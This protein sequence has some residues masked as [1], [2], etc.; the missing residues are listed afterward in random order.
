MSAIWLLA[1]A[2][3]CLSGKWAQHCGH[4]IC[5]NILELS[6]CRLVARVAVSRM[7]MGKTAQLASCRSQRVAFA[8]AACIASIKY[9]AQQKL[10]TCY[11][12]RSVGGGTLLGLRQAPIAADVRLG[13]PKTKLYCPLVHRCLC[14]CRF[15]CWLRLK[16]CSCCN[17]AHALPCCWVQLPSVRT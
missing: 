11:N 15:C 13:L 9:F 14:S 10:C 4:S 2:R 1:G 6:V 12:E 8:V 16:P 5:C 7:H 17:W 3:L